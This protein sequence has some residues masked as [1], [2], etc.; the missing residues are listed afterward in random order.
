MARNS[1]NRMDAVI[2]EDIVV[3][4]RDPR[5]DSMPPKAKPA[6]DPPSAVLPVT[7][8][9]EA[10]TDDRVSAARRQIAQLQ[11]QLVEMQQALSVEGAAR[12]EDAERLE[13]L[14]A[15]EARLSTELRASEGRRESEVASRDA[16]ITELT[17]SLAVQ[18]EATFAADSLNAKLLA[19]VEQRTTEAA[20]ARA[21]VEE[22]D[23]SLVGLRELLDERTS[24]LTSARSRVAELEAEVRD[25]DEELARAREEALAREVALEGEKAST[26]EVCREVE[27]LEAELAT[28]REKNLA[29]TAE[30]ATA[31]SRGDALADDMRTLG[32][33]VERER[34]TAAR[35][36]DLLGDVLRADQALARVKSAAHEAL[37][38]SGAGARKAGQ[39]RPPPLPPRPRG[40]DEV[41]MP[42][43]A[44][45]NPS[46]SDLVLLVDES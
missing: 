45:D 22:R 26:A 11:A 6:S 4:R 25:R 39:Q 1:K 42:P 38:G 9:P 16:R 2:V 13:T 31:Q 30:L 5:A 27:R 12:A 15:T 35:W 19:D 33:E 7:P 24:E 18:T 8:K 29:V 36:A 46:T 23:V 40:S 44:G 14:E 41:T 20:D 43:K 34:A 28:S 37:F 10:K 17:T 3:R 21:L 32:V